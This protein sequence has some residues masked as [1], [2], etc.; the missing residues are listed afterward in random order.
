MTTYKMLLKHKIAKLIWICQ[1]SSWGYILV[2]RTKVEKPIKSIKNNPKK[3]S[4]N[5]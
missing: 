1:M 4:K 5:E 3:D 2:D